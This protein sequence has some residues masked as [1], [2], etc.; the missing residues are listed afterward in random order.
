MFNIQNLEKINTYLKEKITVINQS[1]LIFQAYR[2]PNNDQIFEILNPK[3]SIIAKIIKQYPLFLYRF[4]K[5]NKITSDME[6][7]IVKTIDSNFET[8]CEDISNPTEKIILAKIKRNFG[9]YYTLEKPSFQMCIYGITSNKLTID[10][11]PKEYKTQNNY[12]YLLMFTNTL[13]KIKEITPEII[14][15]AIT[16]RIFKE[17]KEI[18][19][20]LKYINSEDIWETLLTGYPKIL[21]N[22]PKWDKNPQIINVVRTLTLRNNS[23]ITSYIIKNKTSI[24]KQLLI[25]LCDISSNLLT[26]LHDYLKL[27]DEYMLSKIEQNQ[28]SNTRFGI[29]ILNPS[30]AV[31]LKL[32]SLNQY[33]GFLNGKRTDYHKFYNDYDIWMAITEQNSRAY[34]YVPYKF[35]TDELKY[36]V[37]NKDPS[38]IR[39]ISNPSEKIQNF[40]LEN[41][42]IDLYKFIHNPIEKVISEMIKIDAESYR[43]VDFNKYPK[44]LK[45]YIFN[46]I[47]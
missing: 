26:D 28:N 29:N 2:T 32:I 9:V 45:R 11:L 8:T 16:Y 42:L 22:I 36:N 17:T 34:F 7:H 27:S 21:N 31:M 10:E 46:H 33:S 24:D 20:Y 35:R 14:H 18:H 13:N 19:K 6:T 37:V 38:M 25:E 15:R 4:L 47:Y 39:F 40:I 3:K 30:K 12:I 43:F 41:K 44:L 1:K 5:N 23:G